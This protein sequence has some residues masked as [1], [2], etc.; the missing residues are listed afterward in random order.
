[1]RALVVFL[2]VMLVIEVC[3]GAAS[4]LKTEHLFWIERSKNKNRVQYDVCLLP[5]RDLRNADPVVAYWVLE[6]GKKEELSPLQGRYAYGIISQEK[7]DK[8]K[9]RITLAAFKDREIVIERLDGDYRAIIMIEGER[10]LLE[11]VYVM[12]EE[13]PLGFPKISYVDIFGRILQTNQP[14]KERVTPD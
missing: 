14:V 6:N 4:C 7:L 13:N 9:L 10:T 3:A 11:R 5:N 8:N 1:M 2:S 12:A